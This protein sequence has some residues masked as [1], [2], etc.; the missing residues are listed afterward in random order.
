MKTSYHTNY[1]AI[2]SLVIILTIATFLRVWQMEQF[3]PGI[4]GDEATNGLDAIRLWTDPKIRVFLPVNTGREAMFHYFLAI[5]IKIFGNRAFSLRIWSAIVGILVVAGSFRWIKSLFRPS[6]HGLWLAL[7]TSVI[8]AT[9]LWS[10]QVSRIGLRGIFLLP[11]M[12]AAYYFFWEGLRQKKNTLLIWCGLFLGLGAY[13][14]TT[15]RLIPLTFIF[16]TIYLTVFYRRY[17][18]ENVKLTWRALLIAGSI[19]FIIFLPLGWYF[20]NNPNA[21]F[22]RTKQVLISPGYQTIPNDVSTSYVLTQ[23]FEKIRWLIDLGVPVKS[24][25]APLV[26]Q[27]FSFLFWIGLVIGLL[28]IKNRACAF[29]LISFFVG[30]VPLFLTV[31]PTPVRIISALPSSCALWAL[32]VYYPVQWLFGQLKVLTRPVKVLFVMSMLLI[33]TFSSVQLFRVSQWTNLPAMPSLFDNAFV[34]TARH[35]TP[36]VLRDKRKELIPQFIYNWSPAQFIYRDNFSMLSSAQEDKILSPNS[37]TVSVVWPAE[38]PASLYRL[39]SFVLLSPGEG[40]SAGYI[41]KIGQWDQ[42]KFDQFKDI[43]KN[44]RTQP[45]T[46]MIFDETGRL[47]GWIVELEQDDVANS[48]HT[49][50]QNWVNLSFQDVVLIEGFDAWLV[51]NREID[52]AMFLRIQRHLEEQLSF[53]VEVVDLNGLIWGKAQ[54]TLN[55]AF[56]PLN[57]P[58][59]HHLEIRLSDDIPSGTYVLRVTLGT[60]MSAQQLTASDLS[61]NL[62]GQGVIPIGLIQVGNSVQFDN[63]LSVN[64]DDKVG[65]TG[66]QLNQAVS[67]NIFKIGLRWQALRPIDKNYTTTIQLLDQNHQLIAQVD[68]PPF[69][70]NYP[71]TAWLPGMEMPDVYE[72]KL[73]ENI[74]NGIFQLAIGVY[75]P[76]T[77]QRLSVSQTSGIEHNNNLAIL[78]EV[79]ISSGP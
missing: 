53:K 79:R 43:V 68:T 74:P 36:L 50:P 54:T 72:L 60:D 64:F 76:Q 52:L 49:S 10:L 42:E 13:T 24:D 14:Y 5:S 29:L 20:L 58:L 34:V 21:F 55:T 11:F 71:T 28:K 23:W 7:L 75:D 37:D 32:G 1:I 26:S 15:G 78:Q 38:W 33:S 18:A 65:L 9:S 44:Q 62:I 47:L 19:A 51:S 30:T 67:P 12:L 70:G 56:H 6:E 57:Q 31:G 77:L 22:Q 61:G 27:A 35:V 39:S 3:P 2:P 16:Y 41:E 46:E 59:I 63:E 4:S 73:P 8:I 17:G 45:D 25:A 40:T 69:G 66:Y 48:L